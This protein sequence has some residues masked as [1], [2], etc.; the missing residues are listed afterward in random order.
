MNESLDTPRFYLDR[1]ASDVD[2]FPFAA[3]VVA[4]FSQRHPFKQASNEDAAVLIPINL[5]SGVVAVADGC[6][7]MAGGQ[8]AARLAVKHLESSITQSRNEDS[9]N[10]RAAILDGIEAA[11]RTVQ[12]LGTGA[13]TTLAVVAIEGNTI[14]P[15]HV[16][17]SGVLLMGNHGKIK[18][19]TASHSPV[20]YAVQAGMLDEAAAIHHEDLHIVSNVLGTTDTHI[21]VG[22]SRQMA[23]RDTLIVA[24]DGLF[25]NLHTDEIVDIARKGDL[26]AATMELVTAATARMNEESGDD[27]PSKPDDLSVIVFRRSR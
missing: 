14:R 17:D 24:S 2:V 10:L 23:V 13:A 12:D 18:L 27:L 11:N 9:F 7:G 21:E 20:G 15:Y 8:Q 22:P 1:T 26:V 25:D 16:G 3:G 5:T 19:K 4:A 6:G